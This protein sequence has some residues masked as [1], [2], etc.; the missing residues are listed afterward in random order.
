MAQQ[1]EVWIVD[2]FG[3]L[4]DKEIA[5]LHRLLGKVKAHTKNFLN[6]AVNAVVEIA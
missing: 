3:G 6:V 4:N 1:H 2:A 5:T